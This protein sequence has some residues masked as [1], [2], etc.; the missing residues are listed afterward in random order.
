VGLYLITFICGILDA[1]AF[2]GL[3]HVFAEI[4]TGNLVYLTFALGST[5]TGT[6]VAVAPYVVVLGA[7]AVGAVIGGRLLRVPDQVARHRIGFF[8]EWILLIAAIVVTLVAHPSPTGDGRLVVVGL[9][10]AAMAVQN[11][12]VWHWGVRDLATN[13]MTLT[14]TAFLADSRLAG[15]T[16]QRSGRRAGSIVIFSSSAL[17]GAFLVRYGVVWDLLIAWGVLT[18]ALPILL[19]PASESA[20]LERRKAAAS[21]SLATEQAERAADQ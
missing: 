1:A 5:G 17:L 13:V 21:L 12:M 7:F 19:Q 20:V 2:L 16:A 14:M 3:G 15:G 18:V 8:A 4:M 9:L 11:A 6:G 10:A